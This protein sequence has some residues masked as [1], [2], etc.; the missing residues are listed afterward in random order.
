MAAWLDHD[1]PLPVIEGTVIRL[2]VERLP[3]GGVNKPVWLWWSRTNAAPADVDRCWQA[4]LRRFD[5]EPPG[6]R[7]RRAVE[8]GAGDR[9]GLLLA[10]G[11]G[12]TEDE[13]PAVLGR[14]SVLSRF[15]TDFYDCLTAPRTRCSSLANG[16]RA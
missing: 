11:R 16:L 15:R 2:A 3:S 13:L 5:I 14:P 7:G 9:G 4:F 1:G 8:A 12:V 10:P 6:P